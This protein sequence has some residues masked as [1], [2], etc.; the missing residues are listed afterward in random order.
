M[1]EDKVKRVNESGG[2]RKVERDVGK[3]GEKGTETE[4][5]N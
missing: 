2:Y 3:G 1:R 4:T 5:V